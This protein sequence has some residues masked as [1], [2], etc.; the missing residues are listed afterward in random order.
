[1]IAREHQ[2][3]AAIDL[4]P[5]MALPAREEAG[6][7]LQPAERARRLGQLRLTRA[8]G[9]KGCGIM[10]GQIGEG[11]LEGGD[12]RKAVHW[13]TNPSGGTRTMKWPFTP[14]GH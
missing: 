13:A 11:L 1:M 14:S 5:R 10:I 4:R 12:G 2:H 6:D 9:G 7:V 8:G 3:P